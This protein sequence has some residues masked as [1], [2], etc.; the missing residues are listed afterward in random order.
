M[1]LPIYISWTLPIL[2]G[3][4]NFDHSEVDVFSSVVCVISPV[5]PSENVVPVPHI[6]AYVAKSRVHLEMPSRLVA[7]SLHA[8]P[9]RLP[10]LVLRAAVMAR[11]VRV[12]V[13][14]AGG[15]GCSHWSGRMPS[16][17][18]LCCVQQFNFSAPTSQITII[19]ARVAY[20]FKCTCR[21][22]CR[23][24]FR[25]Y[26]MMMSRCLCLIGGCE[27][28]VAGDCGCMLCIS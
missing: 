7:L 13:S 16:C 14:V 17:M 10:M 4:Q 12:R 9:A 20:C 6:P 8:V 26:M 24:E 25:L 5:P 1:C 27:R 15:D 2:I 11:R 19:C 3:S 22:C 18:R 28:V 23:C 21:L